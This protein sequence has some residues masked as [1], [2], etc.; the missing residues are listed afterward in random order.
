MTETDSSLQSAR[1]SSQAP[2]LADVVAVLDAA[3][4]PALAESWDAVGL[5]VGDP[6][7]PVRKVLCAVDPVDSVIDEA[8]AWG[9]DLVVVHH[10]LLLRGVHSVAATSFKGSA[11]HKLIGAGCALYTAHTNADIAEGGANDSL[12]ALVGV[13][14]LAPLEESGIGRVGRLDRPMTLG[15]FAERVAARLPATA[16]GVRVS[17]PLDAPVS[18]VALCSGAGDSLFDAVRESGADVYLTS[19]LRH[20]PASEAREQASLAGGTPYLV[21]TAHWASEWPLLGHVKT[22]LS[23]EFPVEVV[24]STRSTDPWNAVFPSTSGDPS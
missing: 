15:Q 1:D 22:V 16:Q 10:P 8:L 18:V 7:A 24:I 2:T 4:P 19:D 6:S 11:I 23:R 5:V 20:H 3:Y 13:I 21:D 17:G 14:D 12:A 9:A